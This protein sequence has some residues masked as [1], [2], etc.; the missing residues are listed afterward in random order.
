MASVLTENQTTR[1]R[2]GGLKTENPRHR[3]AGVVLIMVAAILALL[4]LLGTIYIIMASADRQGVYASDKAMNMNFAQQSVLNIL[5]GQML[6]QTLDQNGNVLAIDPTSSP[7]SATSI[8][9]FWDYPEM[10]DLV[11]T[12]PTNTGPFYQV[13]VTQTTSQIAPSQPWL[14]NDLPWEPYTNYAA[15]DEVVYPKAAIPPD[16]YTLV[17]QKTHTSGGPGSDPTATGNWQTVSPIPASEPLLSFVT[18]YLYD[19]STGQYDIN[20]AWNFNGSPSGSTGG[21]GGTVDAPNASVVWPRWNWTYSAS[22]PPP[23]APGTPDAVWNLLP[24][25]GPDGTR[26]RFAVRVVDLSGRLNLNSGYPG[27]STTPDPSA[28]ADAYGEYLS[29]APIW[30]QNVSSPDPAATFQNLQTSTAPYGREGTYGTY[31]LAD[32]QTQ[33]FHYELPIDP[34]QF[35]GFASEMELLTYGSYGSAFDGAAPFY[36]RPAQI[37]PNTLGF[38]SGYR[39]FFTAYSWD[40]NYLPQPTAQLPTPPFTFNGNPV[41]NYPDL[42]ELNAA[43]GSAPP[44]TVGEVATNVATAAVECGLSPA[45]LSLGA[46]TIP[47]W[48]HAFALAVNYAT[49]RFDQ[50]AAAGTPSLYSLPYGPSYLDPSGTLHIRSGTP[51]N[52]A[53]YPTTMG[54]ST[55]YYVGLAAQPFINEMEVEITRGG[56]PGPPGPRA[57]SHWAIELMNPFPSTTALSLAGWKLLVFDNPAGTGSPAITVDLGAAAPNGFPSGIA[58][59]TVAGNTQC[60]DV[61][62]SDAGARAW[63]VPGSSAQTAA[64]AGGGTFPLV[65]AVEITRPLYNRSGGLAGEAVVDAMPFD[66][67][68]LHPAPG[69]HLFGDIQR[70]N[71]NQPEWG[72]DSAAADPPGGTVT[73]GSPTQDGTLGGFNGAA[74]V[75]APGV[76]LYD[77]FADGYSPLFGTGTT[78]AID[79][80]LDLVN[81][82]DLNSVARLC[83]IETSITTGSPRSL[84]TL[85]YQIANP[86]TTNPSGYYYVTA[87]AA[88]QPTFTNEP[89]QADAYFDFAYDPRAAFTCVNTTTGAVQPSFLSMVSLND[90]ATVNP[91]GLP[92]PIDAVRI[93]G[94]ININTANANVLLTAFSNVPYYSYYGSTFGANQQAQ[95]QQMAADVIAFRN[96]DAAAGTVYVPTG[97][98]TA[99]PVATPAYPRTG[100]PPAY[101]GYGFRS[102]GD[103]LVALIPNLESSGNTVTTLQQRDAAWADVANFLTVRSDTFAVY[104]LVQALKLNGGYTGAYSPTDWYNANQGKAIGAGPTEYT[105]STDPNNA[106][107]EFI[108][109][110]QKRFIAIIDR[111][112]SNPANP[113]VS[114][115]PVPQ[116]QIVAVKDLPQ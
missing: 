42:V 92:N 51:A 79:S 43:P 103:M 16:M 91:G 89:Y 50:G 20:L 116:P 41:W 55:D 105:I 81:W 47:K 25:S 32:W 28:P 65:G 112:L 9:R 40:R 108:L 68:A 114:G 98:G 107:A 29:S 1:I 56:P 100:G 18:P 62:F 102:L 14:V 73:A 24:Y 72:C 109:E 52:N 27:N 75:G 80:N 77:R 104:G 15:G 99:A 87:Q 12:T 53:S 58:P 34:T 84:A 45:P 74:V 11:A 88:G 35:F 36:C 4:A 97:S 64:Y 3:R 67:S 110:G 46:V 95:Q 82:D 5:R 115:A 7:P 63:L 17:C 37:L 78:A 70:D 33:L 96:R 10:G 57:V 61:V 23:A 111:S 26:Y 85:S 39:D 106:N 54:D 101:P 69:Q 76:P 71:L 83:N 113:S 93:P 60:F 66:F 2:P 48:A 13:D 86:A 38:H 94:K 44:Q 90:R 30:L 8:A 49:Y 59:Y 19:P 21:T 31:N 22:P 6:R